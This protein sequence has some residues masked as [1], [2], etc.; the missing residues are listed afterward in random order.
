[1]FQLDYSLEIIGPAY[2]GLH[3]ILLFLFLE[4][5]NN[6]FFFCLSRLVFFFNFVV[7]H[8]LD[9]TA[10]WILYKPVSGL[11]CP[12]KSDLSLPEP[13]YVTAILYY[14]VKIY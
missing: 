3:A 7:V 12:L 9:I 4:F 11:S 1:M 5:K 6:K 10:Y 13:L 8:W 14:K 2:Y